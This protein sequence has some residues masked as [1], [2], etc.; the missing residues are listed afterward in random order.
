MTI[1]EFIKYLKLGD[2]YAPLISLCVLTN[3]AAFYPFIWKEKYKGAYGVLASTIIWA[4]I[5]MF[6]KFFT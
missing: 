5:V 4:A 1:D 6:L 2:I 3:L